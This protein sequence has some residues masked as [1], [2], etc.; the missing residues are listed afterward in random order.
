MNT[1]S[2]DTLEDRVRKLLRL[3]RSA[4]QAE[5]DLALRRAFQIAEKHQIDVDTL[6]LDSDERRLIARAIRFGYR[7]SKTRFLALGIVKKYFNVT[8]LICHPYVKFIGTAPDVAVAIHVSEFLIA[9]CARDC[10]RVEKASPRRFTP[11]RRRS[12]VAGWYYGVASNLHEGLQQFA[13]TNRQVGIVLSSAE[14]RRAAFLKAL[15]PNQET[16]TRQDKNT[17]RRYLS[18]GHYRGSQVNIR[19]AMTAPIPD[20]PQ[21][22]PVST[23]VGERFEKA[24][25]RLSGPCPPGETHE[26]R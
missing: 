20:A 14:D 24:T 5:A 18:A 11:R 16:V 21:L 23:S 25:R 15:C 1:P 2:R 12:Y 3:A 9:A 4:N 17:D 7:L 19:P 22:Q 10:R 8:P 26:L 6:D 13:L